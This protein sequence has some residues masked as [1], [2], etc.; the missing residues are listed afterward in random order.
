MWGAV[1]AAF[2]LTQVAYA[3]GAVSM[4]V[5][6]GRRSS[7]IV[8]EDTLER[9]VTASDAPVERDRPVLEA[10]G[11]ARKS[12]RDGRG[13][14]KNGP[15]IGPARAAAAD[16]NVAI[17]CRL[18]ESHV[19]PV[20]VLLPIYR[21]RWATLEGTLENVAS[22]RYP[23]DRIAVY[24]VYESHDEDVPAV[25]A[26][27]ATDRDDEL[28][29]VPVEVDRDALAVD[30]S[31]VE[32]TF[33]GTGIPRT[34]AAALTYA[35]TTLSLGPDDVVTVFDSDT[36]VPTDTFEL[37][38]AGLEEYDIVQAKQTA[39]NVDDGLLPTLESMG[40]AA[41]SDVIYPRSAAGPYQLLGKAYFLETRLLYELDRWQLDAVT[42]DMALGVAAFER[43]CSLGVIDRYVQDLCPRS[44]HAWV[45]QKRRWVRG[46]YRHLRSPN[47]SRL[48][49]ARCWS[50]TR[51]TQALSVVN[52]VGIPA[53]LV[54]FLAS[55]RGSVAV[56]TAV[57]PLVAANAVVWL[58]YTARS[59]RA[60]WS[61]LSVDDRKDRLRY[62]LVSNPVTQALYATLWV[63]PI[64]LAVCEVL[65]G[66]DPVFSVT[67]KD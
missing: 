35:F 66:H 8:D 23:T 64:V 5:L 22:Q 6:F 65:R 11:G 2:V 26:E 14:R 30:R 48:E 36:R 46:P 13:A 42:E 50:V 54:V 56:P 53:G 4:L 61:A 59:Y 15:A 19:R 21:E 63:I 38:V 62:S 44:L 41:W 3:A 52:V 28:E 60:A 49:R 18:P 24:V 58:V 33:T 45:G 43:G 37:A 25:L 9:V 67:P 27:L 12:G 10:D 31:A 51:L 57:L 1:I 16:G 40:I 7:P 32:W 34:K 29:V 55:L 17:D 39:R 47:W 20:H